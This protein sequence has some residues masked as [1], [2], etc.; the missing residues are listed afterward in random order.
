MV[1]MMVFGLSAV[2]AKQIVSDAHIGGSKYIFIADDEAKLPKSCFEG[3]TDTE[4]VEL[5]KSTVP[6][7]VGERYTVYVGYLL[8]D[9]TEL[10]KKYNSYLL[11]SEDGSSVFIDQ[12][13]MDGRMVRLVYLFSEEKPTSKVELD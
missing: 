12:D 13:L 8:N 9:A 5:L 11:F 10:V 3:L 1:L 6:E 7:K 2:F 4:I